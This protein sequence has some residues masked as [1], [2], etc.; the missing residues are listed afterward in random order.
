MKH[1]LLTFVAFLITITA[2]SQLQPQTPTLPYFNFGKG[3][4]I[5]APD[6]TFSMNIRF[7]IQNRAAFETVSE[8]DLTISEVEARVRRMRLRFDGF[9]YSPKLTYLLQLS[10]SR[11]DM[12]FE[13]LGYPNVV[14]DAY[15]Q[16]AFTKKFAAGIGQ[17][18][19]PGNRQ[20]V[21]SSGDL[22]LADRS[23]VN[24]TFNIDRDFGIQFI[25]KTNVLVA[26][27]A[28]STGEGRNI[29]SGDNGLAYT[30]RLEFLPFG[31]FTNNGDY[32]EGD[33]VREKKHKISMAIWYS[34]NEDAVRESGQLGTFLY[35]STD[36]TTQG[37]DF[38][39]KYNGL[40]LSSEFVKR[41]SPAPITDDGTGNFKYVYVGVGQNY[42]GSYNFKNNVEL[43][44]RF[45]SVMPDKNELGT[46]K[47]YTEQ[48][49]IGINKYLKG[50]RVKIQ[51]D[52]TFEQV[53]DGS[54]MSKYWIYRF[55][56]ELGI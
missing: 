8:S 24:S 45:S 10:F 15:I 50:H 13:S 48:Y 54:A 2:F 7:R 38:L 31:A 9:V 25:Y 47:K 18:K 35:G 1:P 37:A 11:G 29:T 34:H 20:R 40:A 49:T 28:I 27:G 56:V 14:R 16:Y 30:G 33:L 3:I 39:Y 23:I 42:Q 19:L 46:A 5:T 41:T 52:L 12:D 55:Q 22:Q 51:N 4:G 6:S 53:D 32:F 17:T 26:K 21:N 36:I 43:V 44:G